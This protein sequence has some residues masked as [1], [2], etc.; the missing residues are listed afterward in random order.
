MLRAKL[1]ALL[2]IIET[3][4]LGN[5]SFLRQRY[6]RYPI[7][8]GTYGWPRVIDAGEGATVRIGA[9]CSIAKGVKIMLGGEHHTEWVTTFPFSVL[10]PAARHIGG[11]PQTKGDVII[12]NDVWL[13]EDALILSGVQIGH[14]AVVAARSVVT[15]NVEPYTIVGGNPAR[16]IRRRFSDDVIARL[17][18][19]AWWEW[20]ADEIERALPLLLSA[21]INAFLRYCDTRPSVR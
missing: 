1:F 20:P 14:G 8:H 10:W 11:H 16:V 2:E 3:W 19:S 12:G 17:L 6:S 5:G 15:K 9:F 18:A 4:L 13:G 7:G 21:D